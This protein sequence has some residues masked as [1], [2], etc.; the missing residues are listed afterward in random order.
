MSHSISTT[1]QR[2]AR[3]PRKSVTFSTKCLVHIIPQEQLT[4]QDNEQAEC[5]SDFMVTHAQ[6]LTSQSLAA[7]EPQATPTPK[8][9]VRACPAPPSKPRVSRFTELFSPHGSLAVRS[10]PA[11]PLRAATESTIKR[12]PL[13]PP[14]AQD[15][16]S[17]AA[18][19]HPPRHFRRANTTFDDF[20]PRSQT[21]TWQSEDDAR[22]Q[23][24]VRM[25]AVS[26]LSTA[27][28]QVARKVRGRLG[29][30]LPSTDEMYARMV[31][32]E[33]D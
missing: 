26:G 6:A 8:A 31:G 21:S 32:R 12:K 1:P 28:E 23:R 29:V 4:W 20:L 27:K 9:P 13:P 15:S 11:A 30:R 5:P 7:Q 25:R 16:S 24:S 14:S 3:G 17:A 10:P 18:A 2:R 19:I 33:K 22:R